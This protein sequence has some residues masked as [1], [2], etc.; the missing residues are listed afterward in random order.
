MASSSKFRPHLE[1]YIRGSLTSAFT[2]HL[3]DRDLDA[4]YKEAAAN[5]A[6]KKITG[7]VAQKERVITIREIRGRT[8]K[9]TEDEAEKPKNALRRAEIAAEKKA[10]AEIKA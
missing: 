3:L 9:R 5:A 6:R 1:Q 10:K 4:T 2:Y 7:R 8:T